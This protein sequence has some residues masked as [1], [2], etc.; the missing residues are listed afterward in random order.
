MFTFLMIIAVLAIVAGAGAAAYFYL[1]RSQ[2]SRLAGDFKLYAPYLI[3]QT[4]R[5]RLRVQPLGRDYIGEEDAAAYAEMKKLW[6]GMTKHRMKLIGTFASDEN[7]RVYI[8]GQHPDNKIVG[9]VGL[10]RGMRPFVEFFKLSGSGTV[11]VLSGAPGARAMRLATLTVEPKHNPAWRSAVEAFASTAEGRSL[12]VNNLIVLFER[13]HSARMDHQLKAAPS[14]AEIKSH[15]AAQGA[16]DTLHGQQLDHALEINQVAWRDAVQV[17]LLDNTRRKLK[18][19]V[20]TWSKLEAQLIVIHAGMHVDD[21]IA[22]LAEYPMVDALGVQLKA[23]ELGPLEIF[24]QINEQLAPAD[25]RRLVVE[26]ASP[27]PAAIYARAGAMQSAGVPAQAMA[28]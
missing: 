11:G 20:D 13:V 21:V 7:Q 19:T 18:L 28:A 12:D 3:E 9:L 5:V 22:K 25:R 1:Q 2:V 26:L 15:A 23:Q 6:S 10:Q 24:K 14:L 27:V 16:A 4:A 17:A 8:I